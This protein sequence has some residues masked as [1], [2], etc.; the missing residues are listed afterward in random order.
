MKRMLIILLVGLLSF[1]SFGQNGALYQNWHLISYE[2]E[3]ENVLVSEVLPHI[4]PTL[5]INQDLEY[6]GIAAC[7]NY[8]GNFSYDSVNDLLILDNFDATLNLCDFEIHNDFEVEYFSLFVVDASYNYTI[9]YETNG[10]ESLDLVL[11]SG[12]ILHYSNS[13]IIFSVNDNTLFNINISPNPVSDQLFISSEITVVEKIIV[14]S[15]NGKILFEVAHETNSI[16]VS[17][18]SKGIYFIELFSSEGKSI[19]RFIKN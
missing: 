17:T 9:I 14:Y 5:T 16:D 13:P 7:N 11:R 19:Q 12:I 4:T 2:I 18:L 15:I 3:G 6:S 1:K 8:L 10:S